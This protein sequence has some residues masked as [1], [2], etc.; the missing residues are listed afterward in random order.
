V[1]SRQMAQMR[2][3]FAEIKLAM[4]ERRALAAPVVEV[5]DLEPVAAAQEQLGLF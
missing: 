1:N 5:R 2:E 3:D 4:Q